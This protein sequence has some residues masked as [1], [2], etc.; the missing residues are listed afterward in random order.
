[1]NTIQS[2]ASTAT[3]GPAYLQ[4]PNAA[5]CGVN[6]SVLWLPGPRTPDDCSVGWSGEAVLAR[7]TLSACRPGQ[8]CQRCRDRPELLPRCLIIWPISLQQ[9]PVLSE[10]QL[11]NLFNAACDVGRDQ[12]L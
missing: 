6:G 8:W 7:V 5:A 1:M 10:V 9:P 11:C 3:A 12:Q 4:G 2:Q